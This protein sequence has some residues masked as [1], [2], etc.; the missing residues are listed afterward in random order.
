MPLLHCAKPQCISR[1]WLCAYV[2]LLLAHLALALSLTRCRFN[3]N[4]FAAVHA[5][6]ESTSRRSLMLQQTSIPVD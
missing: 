5:V 6:V 3:P 2:V 4:Q 1:R